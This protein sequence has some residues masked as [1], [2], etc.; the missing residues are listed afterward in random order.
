MIEP[1]FTKGPLTIR[2]SRDGYMID[3]SDIF[4]LAEVY[5]HDEEGLANARLYA[6][7]PYMYDAL[8]KAHDAID[9]LFAR[10]V[11]ADE[12]FMPSKSGSP[13]NDLLEINEAIAKAEKES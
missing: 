1:K 4:A 7:A 3:A 13:W 9:E 2:E 12:S 11:I 10:L 5:G 6:A 8:H